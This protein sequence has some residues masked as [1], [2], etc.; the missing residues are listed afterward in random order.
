MRGDERRGRQSSAAA[1]LDEPGDGGAQGCQSGDLG[2][3]ADGQ[4]ESFE[5]IA[6][7]GSAAQE[8]TLSVGDV[9]KVTDDLGANVLHVL[10]GNEDT[11]NLVGSGWTVA[12]ELEIFDGSGTLYFI[13]TITGTNIP[14]IEYYRTQ[15]APWPP[16]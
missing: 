3:V 6:L 9:L 10:G 13:E 16:K 2:A 14:P 11:L 7:K 15:L 5:V 1:F 4:I 12:A 8:L